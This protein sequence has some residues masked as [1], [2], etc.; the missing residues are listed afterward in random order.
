M[1]QDLA[2]QQATSVLTVIDKM[3]ANPEVDV[4]KLQSMLDMQERI[5]AK[6][7]EMLFNQAMVEALA[8]IPSFEESTDGYNFK[9]A[10]FESINKVVKPI[11]AKHGLFVNFTTNFQD[12]GVFVTAIITHKD[13]HR[14]QSTGLYPFDTSGQK[15]QIQAVGSAISYGKRYQQNALLNIST[16]GEDDDGFASEKKIGKDEIGQLNKGLIQIQQKS[17]DL[18]KYM[19]VDRMSNIPMERYSEAVQYIKN[20]IEVQADDNS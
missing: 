6:N 2:T 11:L 4:E 5:M 10:T 16:H 12:G 3:S 13:G 18:C 19:E 14:E 7:A 15:N 1:K 8:E 9:Y 20:V 17:D